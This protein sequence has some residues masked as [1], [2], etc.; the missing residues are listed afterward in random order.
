MIKQTILIT[1]EVYTAIH[2]FFVPK[3]SIYFKKHLKKIASQAL[4]VID[5]RQIV[6]DKRL[7]TAF[8]T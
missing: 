7:S 8:L 4:V 1:I 3:F 2:K 6:L 5:N